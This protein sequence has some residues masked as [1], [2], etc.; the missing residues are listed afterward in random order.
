M[1]FEVGKFYEVSVDWSDKKIPALCVQVLK[2]CIKFEYLYRD[3]D[4]LNKSVVTKRLNRSSYEDGKDF[5]D[6]YDL[7]S[8]NRT[9]F[10]DETAEKPAVCD[11]VPS[12][13]KVSKQ[14]APKEEP[15]R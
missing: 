4:N 9:T 14:R 10:A 3:G 13:F 15:K 5:A 1:H 7:W 11:D 2:R 8:P 6:S 12:S